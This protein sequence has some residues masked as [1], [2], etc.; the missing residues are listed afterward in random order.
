MKKLISKITFIILVVLSFGCKEKT[1]HELIKPK[2]KSNNSIIEIKDKEEWTKKVS[3]LK[4]MK[5]GDTSITYDYSPMRIK[6]KDNNQVPLSNNK[7]NSEPLDNDFEYNDYWRKEAFKNTKQF[8]RYYIPKD[9]PGCKVTAQGNYR[10]D[11]VTYLGNQIFRVRVYCEF[12]CNNGYNNPSIFTGYASYL[13]NKKWD[14]KLTEQ[15]L[16]D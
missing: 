13:G 15:K 14:I 11:Y 6:N 5:A 12:D 1:T 8:L 16:V 10:A 3:R 9:L 7:S 2:E 4:Q